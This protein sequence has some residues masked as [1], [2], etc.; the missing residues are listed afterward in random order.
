VQRRR[1]TASG[2]RTGIGLAVADVGVVVS[3]ILLNLDR[4]ARLLDDLRAMSDLR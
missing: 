2:A 1:N 3:V 4:L